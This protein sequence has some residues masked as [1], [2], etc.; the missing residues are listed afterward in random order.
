M[1]SFTPWGVVAA[2]VRV[3]KQYAQTCSR[4]VNVYNPCMFVGFT[5]M[6]KCVILEIETT[7]FEER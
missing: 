7:F 4:F 3:E 5:S 6:I 1:N 2:T